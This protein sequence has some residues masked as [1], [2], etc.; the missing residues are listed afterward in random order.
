MFI[1][2]I[3]CP[4][5][6][7]SISN[8]AQSCVHCGYPLSQTKT[9]DNA[10]TVIAERVHFSY[11]ETIICVIILSLFS[12]SFFFGSYSLSSSEDLYLG[13]IFLCITFVYAFFS[14][15]K[16]Y[17]NNRSEPTLISIYQDTLIIENDPDFTIHKKDIYDLSYKIHK[18]FIVT[19]YV[20]TRVEYN[21]G[22]IFI[23]YK[24]NETPYK[25]TIK[26]VLHPESVFEILCSFIE[27]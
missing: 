4:K 11:K 23:F 14:I 17:I 19:P 21:Y 22:K 26:N 2:L 13:I 15:R 6:K 8:Q 7:K 9:V 5:C 3:Y 27:D 10:P 18:G 25:L 24:Q 12:I 20:F 16:I 1:R